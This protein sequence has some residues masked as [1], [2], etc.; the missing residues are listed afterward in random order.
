[1][2]DYPVAVD[3]EVRWGD[4]NARAHVD[5]AAFFRYFEIARV[6]YL[7]RIGMPTPGPAWR[8]FGWVLASTCCRNKSPVTYPDTLTVATGAGALSDDRVLMEYR[9]VSEKLAP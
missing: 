3:I 5:S 9:V 8:D 1:M 2:K 6:A 4:M 7:H